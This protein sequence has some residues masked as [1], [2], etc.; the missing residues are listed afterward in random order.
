MTTEERFARIE[1]QLAVT[2]ETLNVVAQSQ[3]NL[4]TAVRAVVDA[5]SATQNTVQ[6]LAEKIDHYVDAA[7]ARMRR[8]EDNLDGLIRAITAEH[9]NGKGQH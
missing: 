3:V 2:V 9:S 6:Q 5:A 7:D 8:I 1:E 4:Q